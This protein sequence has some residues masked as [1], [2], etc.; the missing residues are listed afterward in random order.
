MSGANDDW[1]TTPSASETT[2]PGIDT[3]MGIQHIGGQAA[4]RADQFDKVK[5]LCIFRKLQS[6]GLQASALGLGQQ[7]TVLR[8]DDDEA[9]PTVA[10][11]QGFSENPHA[12][13]A[14]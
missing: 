9:M 13:P 12:L 3:T 7:A 10:H 2:D 14:P 6:L 8:R 4:Q 5:E 11:P 1:D